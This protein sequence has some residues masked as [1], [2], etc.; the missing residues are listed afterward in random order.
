MEH[1][2][3]PRKLPR[4]VRPFLERARSVFGGGAALESHG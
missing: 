1:P 4:E 3:L 2:S